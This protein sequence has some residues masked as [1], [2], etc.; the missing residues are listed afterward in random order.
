[1]CV[2]VCVCVC[3]YVC[4]YIYIYIYISCT[5]YI[6]NYSKEGNHNLLKINKNLTKEKTT[7]LKGPFN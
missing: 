7:K 1:M 4:M 3:V 2:C 6:N 5:A